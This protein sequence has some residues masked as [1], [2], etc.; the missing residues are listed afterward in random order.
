[1][2]YD[3]ATALASL[4]CRVMIENFV[5]LGLQKSG[6]NFA[7]KKLSVGAWS[8]STFEVANKIQPRSLAKMALDGQWS[9]WLDA[10]FFVANVN[11]NSDGLNVNVNLFENDNVWNAENRNRVVLPKMTFSPL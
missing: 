9:R 7:R 2:H 3:K 11:L 4:V 1:M 5:G 6:D 10:Q 8:W